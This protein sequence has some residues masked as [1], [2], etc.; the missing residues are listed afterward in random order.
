MPKRSV[1]STKKKRTTFWRLKK[2]IS[3][4]LHQ[5]PVANVQYNS[6]SRISSPK[7]SLQDFSQADVLTAECTV[8]HPDINMDSI[9][10]ANVC[11]DSNSHLDISSEPS[12]SFNNVGDSVTT[13]ALMID[14]RYTSISCMAS[15]HSLDIDENSF[16][17]RNVLCSF[18]K[19]F[20]QSHASINYLLKELKEHSCFA[21]I[22]P[23]DARTLLGTPRNESKLV[24]PLAPGYYYHFGLLNGLEKYADTFGDISEHIELVIGIDGLPLSSSSKSSFWPILGY[25]SPRSSFIFIIGLYWGTDKPYDSNEYI[26]EFVKEVE[27]L[28]RNA[29]YI[30]QK[31]VHIK[32]RAFCCDAPAKSFVLKTKGHSGYSSCTKCDCKGEYLSGRM[33]FP[34]KAKHMRT[35][36]DFVAQIDKN[37]HHTDTSATVLLNLK[38]NIIDS[39][40]LD[41]MHLVCLGVVKKLLLLLCKYAPLNLRICNRK[42]EGVSNMD[43]INSGIFSC[44]QG[45]PREFSRRCRSLDDI[46]QWKATEFRLFLLY[47][48]PLVLRENIS[49]SQ[50]KHFHLLSIAISILLD[51]N[52]G[53]LAVCAKV[54]LQNFVSKFSSIYGRHLISH[55]VHGLLHLFNDYQNLGPMDDFSCFP[56]ENYLGQLKKLS[57]KAEKPL[58]QIVNRYY[59]NVN[60]FDGKDEKKKIGLCGEHHRGPVPVAL[61]GNV[62]QYSMYKTEYYTLVVSSKNIKDSYM[63]TNSKDVVQ[64]VNILKIIHSNKILILGRKFNTKENTYE[65]PLNSE[66]LDIYRVKNISNELETY[67]VSHIYK[68]CFIL[69][70]NDVHTALP[71]LHC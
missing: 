56:F 3:N 6:S 65:E 69:T 27:D 26:K 15:E 57:R 36:T 70:V 21:N 30:K 38:I 49:E 44:Q 23:L 17:I 42:K 7:Q 43:R 1:P 4:N 24:K 5:M 46:M 16:D 14:N 55:N 50:Y 18:A 60:I 64:V 12:S 40:P 10:L 29:I 45:L 20:N 35:H 62:C 63:L 59:E 53:Q 13:N 51:R 31:L 11:N 37:Y 34:T 47:I 33:T 2:K 32:V 68:K 22:L 52:L 54:Y 58:Q 61:K 48:G 67:E 28:E 71:L 66:L 39:F 8:S 25:V 19:K 9:M 41:Y